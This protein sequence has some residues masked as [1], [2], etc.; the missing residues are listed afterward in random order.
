IHH[1]DV[2][3]RLH[4]IKYR[5]W[6]DHGITLPA[7]DEWLN[8]TAAFAE[9]VRIFLSA[10]TRKESSRRPVLAHF[11]E[12]MAGAAIPML[13]KESWPGSIIFTTHATLLGRYLAMN[14]DQFYSRLPFYDAY[15][16]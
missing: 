10:L 6:N 9:G 3:A 15:K 1:L 5:L 4:E 13:R 2:F 12:W 8:N 16:E 14:D 7:D 11:H